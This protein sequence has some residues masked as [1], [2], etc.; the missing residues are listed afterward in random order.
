MSCIELL[1]FL[2][3][4]NFVVLTFFCFRRYHFMVNEDY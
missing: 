1:E 2:L 4:R 3:H